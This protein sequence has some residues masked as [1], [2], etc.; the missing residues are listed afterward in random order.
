[1]RN[2]HC[3]VYTKNLFYDDST[4]LAASVDTN[5]NVGKNGKNPRKDCN[6]YFN[7]WTK[8]TY[9]NKPIK[10]VAHTLTNLNFIKALFYI[11]YSSTERNRKTKPIKENSAKP[12]LF[13]L[14]NNMYVFFHSY[15]VQICCYLL[16]F[17]LSMHT[18]Y[19]LTYTQ[20]KKHL[21]YL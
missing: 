13:L 5:R 8:T 14:L 12:K 20:L 18:Q 9:N 16:F 1:M 6:A 21:R 17:G 3:S 19:T 7:S 11:I 4:V 2:V 15:G 10:S